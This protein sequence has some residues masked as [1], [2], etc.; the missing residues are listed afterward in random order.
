VPFRPLTIVAVTPEDVAAAGVGKRALA[1]R[2][3]AR[4]PSLAYWACVALLLAC[5]ALCIWAMATGRL[6]AVIY[7][8]SPAIT[9]ICRVFATLGLLAG[10]P[11]ALATVAHVNRRYV[12]AARRELGDPIC[13]RCGYP[14]RSCGRLVCPECG[15]ANA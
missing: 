15:E 12:Y 6:A 11:T 10:P 9:A 7:T 4:I 5:S 3:N 14:L 13:G 8:P 2:A 1:A